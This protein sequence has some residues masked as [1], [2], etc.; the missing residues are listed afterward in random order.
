VDAGA[1]IEVVSIEGN[2]IVVRRARDEPRK[3]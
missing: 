1:P 3:E 2:R